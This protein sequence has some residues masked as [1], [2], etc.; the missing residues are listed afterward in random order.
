MCPTMS[1]RKLK[2]NNSQSFLQN[3]DPCVRRRD[4]GNYKDSEAGDMFDSL[5]LILTPYDETQYWA[6]IANSSKKRE[7]RYS[8]VFSMRRIL[9][10]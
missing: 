3:I 9:V 8:I 2:Y 6:D 1:L 7:E 4:P 5:A 10:Q